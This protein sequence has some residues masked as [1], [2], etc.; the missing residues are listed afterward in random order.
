MIQASTLSKTTGAPVAFTLIGVSIAVFMLG[1]LGDAGLFG[2]FAQWNQLVEAGEWWRVFS[3]AF[4]H[5]G[6]THL[7]FNM[8]ALY[9]FGPPMERQVGS[10]AFAALYFASA[11]AGGAFAFFLGGPADVIVGASG[12]IFGLFGAWLVASYRSRR[13]PAGA[14]QFRMLMILLGINAALALVIPNISWQGHLGGFS[15]GVLIAALWSK[16]P[17]GSSQGRR[18]AAAVAVGLVAVVLVALL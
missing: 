16:D 2:R 7:L 3:A 11:A 15:A 13:T 5:A 1:Q 18:T 12:A 10:T 14:A 9:V 17:A 8:W 6:L 4:L